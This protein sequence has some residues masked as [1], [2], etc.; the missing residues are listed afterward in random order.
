M[1]APFKVLIAGGSVAGLSLAN[2]LE[3]YGIDFEVFEKHAIIAPQ[4]GA[5][6][7]IFP[8][9]FRILD[10]LGCLDAVDTISTPI[11]SL[12]ITGPDGKQLASHHKFGDYVEELYVSWNTQHGCS[13]F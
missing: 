9:G 5:S 12:M 6:I 10:Q 8:N 3:R 4:L 1:A 7:G 2:M 13:R 11:N